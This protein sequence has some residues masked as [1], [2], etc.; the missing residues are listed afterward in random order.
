MCDVC[1]YIM[2][3]TNMAS[4][5]DR[6]KDENEKSYKLIELLQKYPAIWDV[7]SK[8]FKDRD[9]KKKGFDEISKEMKYSGFL[10]AIFSM[11]M[12]VLL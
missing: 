6:A 7:K 8:E 12:S 10:T 5:M 11:K 9:L 3:T 1:V 4:T 2:S